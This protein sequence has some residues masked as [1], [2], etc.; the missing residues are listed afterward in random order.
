MCCGGD[1]DPESGLGEGWIGE[2]QNELVC[3]VFDEGGSDGRDGRDAE[4]EVFKVRE[5]CRAWNRE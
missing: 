5:G 2:K 4:K 3:Y 1:G